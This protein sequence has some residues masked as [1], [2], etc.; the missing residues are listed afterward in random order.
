MFPHPK[1]LFN[2]ILMLNRLLLWVIPYAYALTITHTGIKEIIPV[3]LPGLAAATLANDALSIYGQVPDNLEAPN[4]FNHF[5]GSLG[6]CAPE[7]QD[8]LLRQKIGALEQQ[9][10]QHKEDYLLKH[11]ECQ[12]KKRLLDLVGKMITG[13][14]CFSRT[15]N[16]HIYSRALSGLT[17]L[18]FITA[19][20]QDAPSKSTGHSINGLSIQ[21]IISISSENITP[22]LNDQVRS[23]ESTCPKQEYC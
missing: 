18:A 14:I 21:D 11:Q 23:A 20:N 17:D 2:S 1:I 10:V 13:G 6:V 5:L 9:F 7:A 15:T 12:D 22:K 19:G 4:G 16:S 3:V 8:S